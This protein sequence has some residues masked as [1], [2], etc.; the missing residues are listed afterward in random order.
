MSTRDAARATENLGYLG[1]FGTLQTDPSRLVDRVLHRRPQ[2]DAQQAMA[3]MLRG[4]T[5]YFTPSGQTESVPVQSPEQLRDLTR[6]VK[7]QVTKAQFRQGT[8]SLAEGFKGIGR[9]FKDG[10]NEAFR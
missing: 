10:F 8:R 3:A 9:Q 5:V 4:Q 1:Q 6:Q 2:A 7:S